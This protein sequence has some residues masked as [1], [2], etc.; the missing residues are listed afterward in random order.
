MARSQLSFNLPGTCPIPQFPSTKFDANSSSAFSYRALLRYNSDLK[1]GEILGGSAASK[2]YGMNCMTFTRE[3]SSQPTISIQDCVFYSGQLIWTYHKD[4]NLFLTNIDSDSTCK[5]KIIEIEGLSVW[6]DEKNDIVIFW[7]C[8]NDSKKISHNE[9]ALVYVN[10]ANVTPHW[11][12]TFDLKVFNR[13]KR[14]TKKMLNFTTLDV[15]AFDVNEKVKTDLSCDSGCTN[16]CTIPEEI[17]EA[18]SGPLIV[19]IFIYILVIIIMC[20]VVV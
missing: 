10:N 11:D 19:V 13:V 14:F 7:V 3:Y 1:I 6:G 20:I 12:G 16:N 8:T 5:D 17:I 15:E 4:Y 9:V 2:D 18:S